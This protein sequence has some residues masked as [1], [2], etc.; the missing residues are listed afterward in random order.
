MEHLQQVWHASRERLPFQ[1]PGSVPQFWDLFVLQS[2]RPDSSNLPFLYSTFQFEY[3]MVLSRFCLVVIKTQ[4]ILLTHTT[5]EGP[6][7]MHYSRDFT[8][9]CLHLVYESCHTK[10]CSI[11]WKHNKCIILNWTLERQRSRS[12]II[13]MQL[14]E[15]F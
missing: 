3:P 12:D 8:F 13:N 11:I 15:I 14:Y 4:K 9:T 7:K 1:T 10:I 5:C 2:L 6:V